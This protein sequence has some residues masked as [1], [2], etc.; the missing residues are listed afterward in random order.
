MNKT[1][2]LQLAHRRTTAAWLCL[3]AFT[4]AATL[5]RMIEVAFKGR[6][7]RKAEQRQGNGEQTTAMRVRIIE[8][9]NSTCYMCKRKLPFEEVTLEHVIPRSRGGDD[10]EANLKVACEP[11]NNRKGDRLPEEC[12]WLKQ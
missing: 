6:S 9:D 11:C 12:E 4:D 1:S 3:D 8:R 2:R 10:S 5:S 7:E